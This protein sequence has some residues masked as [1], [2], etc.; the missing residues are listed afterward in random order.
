VLIGKNKETLHRKSNVIETLLQ[1]GRFVKCKLK[2]HN[3]CLFG[4]K[5][6]CLS[7]VLLVLFFAMPGFAE[8][9]IK[10]DLRLAGE[11]HLLIYFDPNQLID[12]TAMRRPIP[13]K[14]APSATYIITEED[15]RQAGVSQ[16]SD[17]FRWVPGMDVVHRLGNDF[18]ISA[19]GFARPASP[20]LQILIDGRPLYNGFKGGV[21]LSYHPIFLE[22]IERIEVVRGPSG[23]T[24]SNAM[25]GVINI[26]TKK[27]A[28]TQGRFIYGGFGNR[29]LQQ[30]HLRLGGTNG[31]MAWRGSVGA[32]H[33]NNF[34]SS[35]GN[36]NKDY[37]QAF[38]STGRVDLTLDSD[39][40]LTLLGG[41]MNIT[42]GFVATLGFDK[43]RI[44]QQ[45]MN[46]ILARQLEDD[47][48][49][50]IQLVKDFLRW[51]SIADDLHTNKIMLNIQHS[52]ISENHN[53]VWGGDYTRDKYNMKGAG[54]T[55][56]KATPER[57]ANDQV[58]FFIDDE[59]ALTDD[60]WF[61]IGT[62][63]NYNELT[64]FDWAGRTALVW[65]MAPE[66]FIRAAVS[67]SFRMPMMHE[68]FADVV[69]WEDATKTTIKYN[70]TGNESM[71]NEQLLAYELGYSG[72]LAENLE[73][74]IE[75]FLNRHKD[76]IALVDSS[77]QYNQVKQNAYSVKTYGIETAID[78][79]PR[80]W[81]LCRLAH[82]YEHQTDE[83]RLN[84]SSI[85]RLVV[86]TAP[87]HKLALTNRFYLDKST[88]VN[89]ALF[90]SDTY[91]NSKKP[92]RA[93]KIDPYFR[94]DVRLARK[95]WNDSAEVAFGV[96]NLN[97]HFHIEDGVHEN[98]VP[99]QFYVQFFYNF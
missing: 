44:S 36:S 7:V 99:R 32:F 30:G 17:I 58:S 16:L 92:P 85:G 72:R 88:T 10:N 35:R 48:R 69:M 75:G 40:Q 2:G 83:N 53:V 63:L 9:D 96:T 45:Y 29:A 52:F 8:E 73:L 33:N 76:L 87:K 89:T 50:Q 13:P 39:T 61:T 25:N 70:Y 59:I 62:R 26:I 60:L 54:L 14:R 1:A 20:R 11:E 78:Y 91:F 6:L 43:R 55:I 49:L 77:T 37:A 57:F 21:D 94:F 97:D 79:K 56:K 19:R 38:Q 74:N 42:N 47:S 80:P 5:F 31:N 34:G 84:D 93:G 64:Y 81:W 65:E 82:S 90:W 68:E 15:I 12:T 71:D 24:G 66:H 18:A 27:A 23:V 46:L 86:E 28:D 95:I 51:L 98:Q 3:R 22:N 4:D 41:H 67:R